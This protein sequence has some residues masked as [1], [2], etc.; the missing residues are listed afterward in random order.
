[1]QYHD[2]Q[3]LAT[4]AYESQWPV[5]DLPE[6]VFAGRSNAGKSTLINALTN[7]TKLAYTGKTP[8]KTRLL[9]FFT[10]DNKVVFTDA[11]GYGY[12]TSDAKSALAFGKLI[13]PYFEKRKQLR[14]MVLVLDARRKPTEEDRQMIDYARKA[15]LAIITACTKSDKLSRGAYLS[16][17]RLI[18]QQL[19]LPLSALH[20][21]DSVRKKGIDEIW[22]EIERIIA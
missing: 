12:A 8:G 1:M 17:A 9:N 7:R 19:D 16:N 4:A 10:V 11:P 6:I 3:L 5:S 14:A 2:A 18:A 15:H 21:V 22:N 13:E 20:P